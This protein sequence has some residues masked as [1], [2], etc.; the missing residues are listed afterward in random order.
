MNL[1]LKRRR[2]LPLAGIAGAACAIRLPAARAA[3]Y[4]SQPITF[5]IPDGLGGTTSALV[6]E[7]G[8]QLAR[9]FDPPVEVEPLAD[10]GA[11]GQK[12]ALDIFHAAPD[13]YTIGMLGSVTRINGANILGKLTWICN[14]NRTQFALGVNA[15]SSINNLADLRKLAQQ[16][17]IRFSSSSKTSIS[18]F[19]TALFAKLSGIPANIV[20][21]YKGASESMLAVA[22]GE[23]DATCQ[24]FP[25]IAIMIQSGLM[26]PI[27]AMADTSPYPGVEDATTIDRPDL[28]EVVSLNC[29]AAPPGL[30]APL[31]ATLSAAFAKISA[32]PATLAWAKKLHI[33]INYLG[34]EQARQAV[35]SQIAVVR[36]WQ[37][38]I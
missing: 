25:T 22:R 14:L 36:K 5:I 23:V 38:K 13:G 35:R 24:N 27:F 28:S 33:P 10:P 31:A 6:R 9:Y 21:G 11:G 37:D 17:P 19:A 30:P 1:T 8:A 16:R 3:S 15:K 18:Y 32:D 34:P 20:T 26:R 2:L 4:P 29:V 7:F 12:A